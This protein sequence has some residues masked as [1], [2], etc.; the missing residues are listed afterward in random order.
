MAKVGRCYSPSFS[1]DNRSIAL[2]SDL[3]GVPQVWTVP[4]EGGWPK[5]VTP[6]EDPI[7]SVSWSPDGSLLAFS[8]APGGGMNQQAYLVKPEGGEMKLITQGGTDTNWLGPWSPDGSLLAISSN[9]RARDAMDGCLF[10]VAKGEMRLVVRNTGIGSF[11][12]LSRDCRSGIFCRVESRGNDNLFLVDL[13]SG[14]ELLL[15]PHSGPGD[16]NLGRFSPDGATIYLITNQD[17]NLTAFGRVRISGGAAGKIVGPIEVLRERP[18]AELA[19]FEISRDGSLAVLVWNLA[20]KNVLEF[21]NLD[22][23][24]VG[25]CPPL[26]GEVV[27]GVEPTKDDGRILAVAV[28]GS[29]RP[30]DIWLVDRMTMQVLQLTNSPHAGIDL[31][32]LVSPTL[33]NFSAEDGL[34]LT[35]WLYRPRG[36]SGKDPVVL[37]FHGGPESVESPHFDYVYQ[38]LLSQGIAVF[39]PNVRGSAG[40]GKG[41]LHMD[42][43]TLRFNAIKDIKAC[44]EYLTKEGL[45]DPSRVGIMGGSY[46]GYMTMAGLTEYPDL[47]AAGVD[48]Y[49]I[50]NFES[51]FANTEPWMATI[52][53]REYGDPDTEGEMLRS[54]SPLHRIDRVV[55]PTLVLHGANDTNVPVIEAEQVVQSLRNR[56]VQVEYVLFP[57]EGHGFVKA[58]NRIR[59]AVAIVSWFTTYLKPRYQAR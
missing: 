21:M 3:T 16:F 5:L 56:G 4:I 37:S 22:N 38:A 46:G 32:R 26:P 20:G 12:D 8:L 34:A 29:A 19:S 41:F 10:D 2:V 57:D 27:L 1:P 35:G 31:D 28:S 58:E 50:V 47:F 51:F 24:M 45:A 14:E 6:L 9:S 36:S 33:V 17:R 13:N 54:L 39:A 52:S 15:T 18:D 30:C 42:D 7:I 44:V 53:K 43:G 55:A 48:L 23:L 49:G 25:F 59:S 40:F 11:V